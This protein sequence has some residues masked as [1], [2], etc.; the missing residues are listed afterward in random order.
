MG[1]MIRSR[2]SSHGTAKKWWKAIF[3][4]LLDQTII[5]TFRSWNSLVARKLKVKQIVE[6]IFY[7]LVGDKDNLLINSNPIR[8][9]SRSTVRTP[10]LPVAKKKRTRIDI[11]KESDPNRFKGTIHLPVLNMCG[12]KVNFQD[13]VLCR[14]SGRNRVR[15]SVFCTFCNVSLC[16]KHNCFYLWHKNDSSS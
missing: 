1:D 10:D 15:T 13:C 11:T 2:T 8:P 3:F 9:R 4:Y 5:A 14:V 12:E 6:Q 7:E 16:T